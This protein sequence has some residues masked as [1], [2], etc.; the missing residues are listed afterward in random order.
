M[1]EVCCPVCGGALDTAGKTWRCA[2]G[3]SFDMA[4]QGYVNLLTVTRKHSKNPGDSLEQIAARKAF[5]DAGYYRPVA[6]RVCGILKEEN[7]GTVLDAGCGEGYYLWNVGQVLPAA[8]RWG[9]DVAKDAVRYAAV[10]DKAAHWLTATAAHLPFPDGS[11]D[12]LMSMF[13]LTAAAEY[14]RVLRPGGLFLQ[15]LAGPEHLMGL[16][17]LIYPEIFRREKDQR[18]TLEGFRLER[19]E[20]LEFSFTLT[21]HQQIWNLLAMTPHF[22]RIG[23]EGAQRAR[24]AGTLTDTAQ[25]VFNCYRAI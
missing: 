25:V 10:R 16:K 8:E 17:T 19:S 23:P 24:E 3:H 9:V 20:T 5:L 15:V 4:R 13:A 12:C 22:L 11:F 18:Q 2:E 6:E 21:E 14:C 7:P 1:V